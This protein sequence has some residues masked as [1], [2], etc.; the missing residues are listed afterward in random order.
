MKRTNSQL[1]DDFPEFNVMSQV[2]VI[3]THDI[4]DLCI[5]PSSLVDCLV[6][7]KVQNAGNQKFSV[8]LSKQFTLHFIFAV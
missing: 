4:Q 7:Y 1:R 8:P 3:S 6:L 5:T 2:A